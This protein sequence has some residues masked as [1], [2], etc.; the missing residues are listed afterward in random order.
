MDSTF[1]L[2]TL[3][4]GDAFS[5]IYYHT[6]FVF[7]AEGFNLLLDCPEPLRKMLRESS[8]QAG[9]PLTLEEID[10]ILVTHL[11]ADHIGGFETYCYYKKFFQGRLGT[12]HTS[13]EVLDVLWP[14]R[15]SGAMGRTVDVKTGVP[16]ANT[17]EDYYRTKMLAYGRENPIGPFRVSIHRANHSIPTVGVIVRHGDLSVGYSCDTAYDRDH[18]DWLSGCDMVIHETGEGLHT[19]LDDLLALPEELRAKLWLVHYPDDFDVDNAPLRC[20]RQGRLYSV[21]QAAAP[22]VL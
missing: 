10:D 11:H 18:I 8:E 4:V 2:M 6:S 22:Q 12:L 3:G 1:Q 17:P 14:K 20:L 15:L 7:R 21:A 5:R 9:L 13:P 19:P 16:S